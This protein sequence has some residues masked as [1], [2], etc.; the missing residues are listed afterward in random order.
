MEIILY[1]M[2]EELIKVDKVISDDISLTGALRSE[3]DVVRPIFRFQ[4]DVGVHRNYAFIPD[5]GRYYFI[6]KITVIRDD[7]YEIELE[8]DVLKSFST[9]IRD[10]TCV[11]KR[12]QNVYNMYL[13]DPLFKSYTYTRVQTKTFPNGFNDEPEFILTVAGG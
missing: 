6:K 11:I 2:L 5:F 10:L 8:V 3:A 12:Q 7:M 4:S 9:Y 1:N 13:D